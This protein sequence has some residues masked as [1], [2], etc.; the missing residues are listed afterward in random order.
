MFLTYKR[1]R[2]LTLTGH[3][4]LKR[5]KARLWPTYLTG[6]CEWHT[7]RVVGDLANGQTLPRVTRDRQLYRGMI[8]PL[9]KE[10]S[11]QNEKKF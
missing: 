8:S 3:I 7:G 2:N 4:R 6:V 1:G 10:H 5:E 11:S 9:L